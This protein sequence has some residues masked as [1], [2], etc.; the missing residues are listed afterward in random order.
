MAAAHIIA[1]TVASGAFVAG[2]DAGHAFND[3]PWF[4]GRVVPEDIWLSQL[5]WRNIFENT[6]TVQWDHRLLAYTSLASVAAVFLKARSSTGA[7]SSAAGAATGRGRSGWRLLPRPVQRGVG[8][9]GA[10]VAVQ[11]SLGITT[12]TM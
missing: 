12:L 6:A 8:A 1:L 5:G 11:A 7:T 4:A 10:M 9:L 2:N 3:W